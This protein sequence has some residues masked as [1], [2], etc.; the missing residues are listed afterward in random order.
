MKYDVF[1]SYSTKDQCEVEKICSHLES[2]GIKC[3]ISYRDIPKWSIWADEIVDALEQSAMMLVV[4][5]DNFNQSQEVSREI[6]IMAKSNRPIMTFKLSDTPFQGAKK[7]YLENR[8]WIN[9]YPKPERHYPELLDDVLRLLNREKEPSHV[10]PPQKEDNSPKKNFVRWIIPLLAMLLILGIALVLTNKHSHRI[11]SPQNVEKASIDS[12]TGLDSMESK[13]LVTAVP[14][15]V[16]LTTDSTAI[17]EKKDSKIVIENAAEKDAKEV[18]AHTTARNVASKVHSYTAN[19]I[20][21]NMLEVKGGTFTMGATEEQKAQAYD[22]ELNT[23]NVTLSSFLIGQTEV[24]QSL[25][26]AVMGNNPSI[27]VAE[28]NPVENVSWSDCQSFLTK[29]NALTGKKFSLPTEAQWEYAARG[30]KTRSTL[31]S[32]GNNINEIAWY[33]G[34]SNSTPHKVQAKKPNSLGVYDMS[35]NVGEWCKD[36]Y[37]EYTSAT[38]S[39]PIATSTEGSYVIRGGDCT[40]QARGCR[41]S[42]RSSNNGSKKDGTTGLRLALDAY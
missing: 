9:A 32:G 13:P 34:N 29:L 26:E 2:N 27:H 6:E 18:E 10:L 40:L 35:G 1:V 17:A 12:L 16:L 20:S 5:S 38:Q 3:F 8:N 42:Y 41:V 28:N 31:F 33:V 24:T 14:S 22:D 37:S 21:F 36:G 23:H 25:W 15:E 39:N 11:S 4:F 30:G 19:G 7:Y